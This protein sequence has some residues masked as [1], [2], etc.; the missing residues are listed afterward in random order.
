MM[1]LRFIM[2]DFRFGNVRVWFNA[3]QPCLKLVCNFRVFLR[4][5]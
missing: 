3:K 4:W 2:K 5:V 1:E